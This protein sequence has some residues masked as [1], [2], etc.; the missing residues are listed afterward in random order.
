ME[1]GNHLTVQWMF[2]VSVAT[3]LFMIVG[4][5]KIM[6]EEEED[7]SYIRPVSG[8]LIAAGIIILLVPLYGHSEYSCFLIHH[9]PDFIC[10]RFYWH[11]ELGSL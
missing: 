3:I 4:I 2:C 10:P 1:T 9:C 11:T 6:K 5:A 7:R 8:L